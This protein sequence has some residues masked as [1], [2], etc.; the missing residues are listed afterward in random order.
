MCLT[1]GVKSSLK[2]ADIRMGVT[3]LA[4][5]WLAGSP[6]ALHDGKVRQQEAGTTLPCLSIITDLFESGTLASMAYQYRLVEEDLRHRLAQR[7]WAIEEQIPGISA[8][9]EHY[10]ASLGTIR[11]AQD[12]LVAEGLLRREQGR[13]VFVA[14][15]PE[16]A[17]AQ[18]TARALIREAVS[19]LARASSLLEQES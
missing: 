1:P 19:L 10:D 5:R 16:P 12:P 18:D 13:G 15:Y 8:L 6:A 14:A 9:M 7:E 3:L 2:A 17:P 11:R 4:A